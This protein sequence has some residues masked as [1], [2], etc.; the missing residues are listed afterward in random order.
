VNR[1]SF[2]APAAALMFV[3]SLAFA[4]SAAAA[5]PFEHGLLWRLEKPGAAPSWVYGTLHSSDPRVIELP[6]PVAGALA[7]ARTFALEI[8]LTDVEG[9]A[10]VEA[11]Q[12]DDGR[13]L[14]PLLG[15]EA[16]GRLREVLGA[17]APS[18]EVLA[19]T[20][21]WAALLRIDAAR[22]VSSGPTLDRRLYLA[23]RERHLTV[24]GLEDIDEQVAAFDGI[25]MITQVAILKHTL[26]HLP[27]IEAQAEP[28]VRAW[29]TGDLAA[30]ASINASIAGKDPD[31][32]RH[33]AVLVHQLV[34]NRSVLM[35]HRLFL[36]LSRGHV[37]VAVGALHLYGSKGLLALLRAQGYR[38]HRVY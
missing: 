13:R 5:Q 2:A 25:P 33:Y 26:D 15:E 34:E 18:E 27:Q 8:Y 7:A 28:T 4:A 21:P 22:A 20:K 14:A 12:F 37:F 19:K 3:L 36:P 10:F 38:V 32:A 17:S 35:A 6:L 9:A 11:T 23:A 31:L 30:L 1:R 29:L 16:Y 24:I